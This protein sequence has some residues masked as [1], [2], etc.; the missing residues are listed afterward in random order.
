MTKIMVIKVE[1]V[2]S[3]DIKPGELFSVA[4]MEHWDSV[5][6]RVGDRL[7]IGEMVY[8]RTNAPTPDS[9]R[10]QDLVLLTIEYEDVPDH[11]SYHLDMG[12]GGVEQSPNPNCPYCTGDLAE[13]PNTLGIRESS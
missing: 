12:P 5:N 4:K 11:A 1:K 6:E 7:P 9:E 2:I 8:I 13:E 3:Q 10:D